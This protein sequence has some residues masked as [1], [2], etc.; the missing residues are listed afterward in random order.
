VQEEQLLEIARGEGLRMV[1]PNSLGIRN[2]AAE[3]RL[4]ATFTEAGV[5]AGA[6]AICSS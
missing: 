4:N 2:T 5:P 6:L 3:V 1:G